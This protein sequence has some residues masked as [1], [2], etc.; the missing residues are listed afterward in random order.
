MSK[1]RK[2]RNGSRNGQGGK[3]ASLIRKLSVTAAVAGQTSAATA[4]VGSTTRATIPCYYSRRVTEPSDSA[5]TT[6][7]SA[8]R[9]EGWV[10][11][12][13]P[14]FIFA[15]GRWVPAPMATAPGLVTA[16]VA[17]PRQVQYQLME[18]DNP[19]PGQ[20]LARWVTRPAMTGPP[21]K[22]MQLSRPTQLE[23]Q[24]AG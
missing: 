19:M 9:S 4:G 13:S 5:T 21:R 18:V 1:R 7:T 15:S 11:K 23:E 22:A 12:P 6:T 3:F 20:R 14:Q 10:F 16:L 24:G 17:G 8:P 2:R